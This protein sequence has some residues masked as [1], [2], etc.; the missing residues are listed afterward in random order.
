MADLETLLATLPYW[1]RRRGRKSV[2]KLGGSAMEDPTGLSAA[3][4]DLAWLHVVGQRVVVVH[5]GGKAIDRALEA[6]GIT[7][8][9]VD[10]RRVT[11]AATLDVVV[12][13]LGSELNGDLVARL[14]E[15]GAPALGLSHLLAG[16]LLD[17]RLGRVGAVRAVD[18]AL[19]D[20]FDGIA[21]LPS[22]ARDT[23][24]AW[25]NVNADDAAA[26]VATRWAADELIFLTDTPGLLRSPADPTSRI[27]RLT[28]AEAADLTAAGVISG[29]M[30]PKVE[31]CLAALAHGVGRVQILDGRAPHALLLEALTGVAP[32]TTFCR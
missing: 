11:D 14:R 15:A 13:V 5:G 24:G 1:T 21:V 12:R 8:K 4:R 18:T 6:A 20:A 29:G 28:P 23:D 16:E 31:G 10:G 26:A 25:L 7:P 9:K 27:D 30:V 32:G 2:V 19:L 22:L 17:P 3:I